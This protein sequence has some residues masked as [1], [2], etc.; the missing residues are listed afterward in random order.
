MVEF[1]NRSSLGVAAPWKENKEDNV[2]GQDQPSPG[3]ALLGLIFLDLMS[4]SVD[5]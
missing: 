4:V 1:N 3:T 2:E 5:M